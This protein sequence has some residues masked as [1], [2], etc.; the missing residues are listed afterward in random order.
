MDYNFIK[1]KTNEKL[2]S[3]TARKVFIAHI[4]NL[5][6]NSYIMEFVKDYYKVPQSSK[7]FIP[8]CHFFRILN[9]LI[10]KREKHDEPISE[11][12]IVE[13]FF[14]LVFEEKIPFIF[15]TGEVRRIL[16][17]SYGI[18]EK[19]LLIN[20]FGSTDF[21]D[22]PEAYFTPEDAYYINTHLESKIIISGRVYSKPEILE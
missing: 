1:D 14:K 17:G 2:S 4:K 7:M 18:A 21:L 8:V 11:F 22:E 12:I 20:A 9:V 10:D 6:N 16:D 19:N 3:K 15:Y 5:I 13:D